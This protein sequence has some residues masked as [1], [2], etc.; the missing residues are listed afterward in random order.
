MSLPERQNHR[1]LQNFG[2]LVFEILDQSLFVGEIIGINSL[3]KLADLSENE[4]QHLFA[5]AMP[6]E[7]CG[8]GC[9]MM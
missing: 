4:Q 8:G 6:A 7:Y 3:K 2:P 5:A 9:V 1:I